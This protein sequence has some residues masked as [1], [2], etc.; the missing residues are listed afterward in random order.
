MS[1]QSI[2]L[3]FGSKAKLLQALLDHLNETYVFPAYE[4]YD[5]W[6]AASGVDALDA[7]VQ[8]VA[9]TSGPIL[10]IANAVDAARRSDP[11][12]DEIWQVPTRGRYHDCLRIVRWL[13]AD[14]TL[15]AS[16]TIPD[17]ARW[18]WAT[19]SIRAY[20][21]LTTTGWSTRRYISHTQ[22]CLRAALTTD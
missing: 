8:V 20:E 19:T 18:L 7:W 5:L 13:A 14:G 15:A 21:D 6:N 10:G 11:D 9:A 12:A 1:R 17:A 22:R 4:R 2:Y 3:H 16:W